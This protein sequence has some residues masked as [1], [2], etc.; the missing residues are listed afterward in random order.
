MM[1]STTAHER[2]NNT[3]NQHCTQN[4]NHFLR[5]ND[6]LVKFALN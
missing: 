1:I 5:K 6:W 2:V 3:G 4:I